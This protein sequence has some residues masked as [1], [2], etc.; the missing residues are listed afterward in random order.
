MNF[1]TAKTNMLMNQI[2]TWDFIS[3]DVLTKMQ[4][5]QREEFVP[6]TQRKLAFSDIELPIGHDQFMMK[7]VVEGRV[8]QALNLTGEESVLEIGTGSGY[9]TALLA[10]S[11][12]QVKS[13]DIF[14]DF[15]E[16]AQEKL[17]DAKI[18]NIELLNQDVFEIN[19]EETYDVIVLTGSLQQCPDFLFDN[20]KPGG[21]L[22]AIVGTAPV[23]TASIFTKGEDSISQVDLFETVVG[24]LKTPKKQPEF[25]L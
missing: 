14:D 5:L 17:K 25:E 24:A 8:L 11:A 19:S 18:D 9:M 12:K 15:L 23:M 6:V 4:K 10:L 22:F 7:P 1:N 16:S 20:L 2:R 21:K 3:P 13:V